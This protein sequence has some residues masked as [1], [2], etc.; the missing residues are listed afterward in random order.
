[1]ASQP[2][3]EVEL[4]VRNGQLHQLRVSGMGIAAQDDGGLGPGCP[5]PFDDFS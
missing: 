1:M 2:K 3:E 4:Q 5:Q